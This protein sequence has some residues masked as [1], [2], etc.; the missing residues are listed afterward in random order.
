MIISGHTCVVENAEHSYTVDLCVCKVC[1]CILQT[2]V[3]VTCVGNP[4]FCSVCANIIQH[5]VC[6]SS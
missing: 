6:F 4:F 2:L 3:T 5:I 1:I